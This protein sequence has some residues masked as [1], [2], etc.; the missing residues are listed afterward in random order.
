MGNFIAREGPFMKKKGI[1]NFYGAMM[2][3]ALVPMVLAIVISMFV[4][5]G[6]AKKD[7]TEMAHNY[8]LSM[9]E[10]EGAELAEEIEIEGVAKALSQEGLTETYAGVKLEGIESSYVYVVDP[11]G[12]MLFHPTASK[13]G[14]PV[15]NEV[16]TKLVG[17]MKSGIKVGHDV[18]EYK[19]NGEMKYA[20]Y[21]ANE[22]QDY[23]LVVSADESDVLASVSSITKIGIGIAAGLVVFFA[24]IALIVARAIATPL[25]KIAKQTTTLSTGDT[26]IDTDI[27][28]IITETIQII[29]ALTT[30]KGA[31]KDS[32]GAVKESAESLTGA[33]A[34]V[35]EKT[36]LNVDSVSQ[37]NEAINEVA[38]TSQSVAENAQLIADRAVTLGDNIDSLT[39][40]VT[41]LK[42]ASEEIAQ[43]N[44][45]ATGYMHTVMESSNESV[46]AVQTISEKINAT[47]EAVKNITEC[48]QMIE[49]ISSQTNLLSLNASIEAARAGEAGRGFAVVAEEIRKLADS[50]GESAKEIK[51]IVESVTLLSEETVEV[52]SRVAEIISNEQKYINDTQ[53]K[54]GVLSSSVDG[55]IEEIGKIKKMTEALGRIKNEL[56]SATSDLGAISEE[57]GASAEEVSASCHTV[58]DAC[59]D[60]QAR[61]EEMRAIND[62]L[63]SAVEFF[64]L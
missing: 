55:S 3:L 18:V 27:K 34:D 2:L 15:T 5:I 47:N 21:Y 50:S 63:V 11:N 36:A 19:F 57:L 58:A 53:A 26:N 41:A 4:L 39:E 46:D 48:V 61:T 62:H 14:Q 16:V 35:D 43:A 30:L 24:L 37:I 56:T 31:L 44:K 8:I 54:F 42:D 10:A 38:E 32:L 28:S 59:T 64:K 25:Q 12:T 60:T 13:I 9:A 40:N 29:E 22:S 23:I 33:V 17:D 51:T 20:G 49:D 45:E 52:A 6:N 1:M 7:I